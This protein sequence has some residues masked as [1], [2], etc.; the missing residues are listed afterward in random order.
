MS[1]NSP[2]LSSLRWKDI[3]RVKGARFTPL[4]APE[5]GLPAM[6]EGGSSKFILLE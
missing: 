3:S 4:P 2:L 6:V 1:S 5:K